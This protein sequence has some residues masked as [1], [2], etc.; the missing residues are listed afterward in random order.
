M[1]TNTI[2]NKRALT[3]GRLQIVEYVIRYF[4]GKSFIRH[5]F[6]FNQEKEMIEH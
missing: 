3:V 4:Y 6:F 2:Q 1:F 5:G